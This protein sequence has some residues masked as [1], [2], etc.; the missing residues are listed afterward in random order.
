MLFFLAVAKRQVGWSSETWDGLLLSMLDFLCTHGG[1]YDLYAGSDWDR[2]RQSG[3]NQRISFCGFGAKFWT[4][5]KHHLLQQSH[6]SQ[7]RHRHGYLR[8]ILTT[9]PL[10]HRLALHLPAQWGIPTILGYSHVSRKSLQGWAHWNTCLMLLL[11]PSLYPAQPD[12]PRTPAS[13][14]AYTAAA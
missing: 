1:Q 4:P 13:R 9:G 14:L 7:P 11:I 10:M 8:S 2:S 3:A 6:G 5:L 12:F